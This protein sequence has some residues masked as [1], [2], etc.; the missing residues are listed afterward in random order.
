MTDT[1]SPAEVR[2]ALERQGVPHAKIVQV[3]GDFSPVEMH[4]PVREVP[5][6]LTIPWSKLVSDNDKYTP[7]LRGHESKPRTILTQRYRDA[8]T[9][10]HEQGLKAMH[11]IAYVET[12]SYTM[13]TG[14]IYAPWKQ[15]CRLAARVYVPDR[16]VHDVGNFR[17]LVTDALEK[18]VI[19]N[20]KWLWEEHW[21]RA[22]VDVDRPRAEITISP[23]ENA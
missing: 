16:R 2:R 14:S 18:A 15:P 17:K 21:I 1:L 7:V 10:I 20:D 11:E 8:K 9:W 19:A 12:A 22:G 4:L 3:V 5:V 23:R 6:T 13:A